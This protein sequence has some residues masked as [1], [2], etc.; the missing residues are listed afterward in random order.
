V[1]INNILFYTLSFFYFI[2]I[3]FTTVKAIKLLSSK[4]RRALISITDAYKTTSTE[5]LQG[6]GGCLT[7]DL[8]LKILAIKEKVRLGQASSN[9]IQEVLEEILE[10]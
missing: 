8:E 1:I 3:C 5:A 9:K 6:I 2:F 10:T 4:Q 7:L